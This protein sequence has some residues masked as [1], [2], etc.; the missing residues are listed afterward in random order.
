[1]RA[2]VIDQPGGPEVLKLGDA[3]TPEAGPGE[4]LVRVRAA[5]VNRADLQ[6]REG[7]YPPPPGASDILG[8][9]VAGEITAV[10]AGV[11]GWQSGARV[12][13]LLPGGGYAEYAAIP[14]AMAMPLPDNLSFEHAAGI[15]E[16]FLTA[17]LALF[18]L[19]DL[20]AG[21]AVLIHAGA[22]GVG[23]AAIQLAKEA[24]ATVFATAG[25]DEKT[26]A[27][28]AL[29]A[30]AAINYRTEDF[31]ARVKELTDGAG[32]ALILDFIGVDYWER[33]LAVLAMEGRIIV[34][35]TLS[36]G[37]VAMNLGA[38]MGKRAQVIGTTL[39]GRPLGQKTALTRAFAT[40]ALH[41]FASGRV[42]PV[43]DTIYPLAH[44][45]EA[46]RRMASN[47]NIGKLIL[48]VD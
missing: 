10:G 41:R 27:C 31:A 16:A 2:I 17:H 3:P 26:A 32:V 45:A 38:L 33:N 29:G 18:P 34:I 11:S 13:A 30:T 8:L 4:L 1:M 47:A 24:G 42:Q 36:G 39:R 43:I 7:K 20:T 40:F 14:A 12:M 48:R 19:G 9:E 21:Q 44:A 37:N 6:Q 22:S 5:G 23:T 35:S 46:H 15:P 28:L 25:T